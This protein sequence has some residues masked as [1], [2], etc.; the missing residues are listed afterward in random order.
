MKGIC[1]IS[2][3]ACRLEPSDRSEMVNQLLYGESY[4]VVE[5]QARWLRTISDVDGYEAWI[6]E[7]QFTEYQED[8]FK[9]HSP[10]NTTARLHLT[11]PQ[12]SFIQLSPASRVNIQEV[13]VL[14]IVGN[15]HKDSALIPLKKEGILPLAFS[16]LN[17]PYLWGGRSIW[18]IDCS[19]FIQVLFLCAGVSLPR[20]AF[21]QALEGEII[22]FGDHQTLDLAY[23]SN[24]KGRIVHVGLMIDEESIIHASGRVRIDSL[25]KEGIIHSESGKRTHTLSHLRRLVL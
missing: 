2:T 14:E 20:D 9:N 24:P 23:F 16:F 7:E 1:K 19:G 5:E 18:G 15:S 22:A 12:S 11:D 3:M 13:E 4:S 6:P 21:E 8:S 10:I 25:T 17:S